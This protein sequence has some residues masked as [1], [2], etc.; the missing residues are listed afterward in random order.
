MK[1]SPI[2]S[3]ELEPPLF[4]AEDVRA[5]EVPVDL[6]VPP[7]LVSLLVV[8][9]LAILFSWNCPF[10]AQTHGAMSVSRRTINIER[11]GGRQ[12]PM[13]TGVPTSVTE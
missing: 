5:T 9:F 2:P 12:V 1:A 13:K 11:K 4:R 3:C 8:A 7:R 6:V 10:A